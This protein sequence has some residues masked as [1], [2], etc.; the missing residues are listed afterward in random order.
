MLAWK[1]LLGEFVTSGRLQEIIKK[2]T[3]DAKNTAKAELQDESRRGKPKAGGSSVVQSKLP[4]AEA[5]KINNA[6]GLSK[7]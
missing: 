5:Q 7:K 6:F 1:Y 2:T 4:A 3:D